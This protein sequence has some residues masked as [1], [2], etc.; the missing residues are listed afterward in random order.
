VRSPGLPRAAATIA[1]ATA[2]VAFAA[3]A[4]AACAGSGGLFAGGR[5]WPAFAADVYAMPADARETLQ[6]ATAVEHAADG[7]HDAA[8]RLAILTATPD[9]S[10]QDL[11]AALDLLDTAEADLGSRDGGNRDFIAFFRPL[12]L[13]L[14]SQRSAL[15]TESLTRQALEAQI[16]ELKALEESLNAGRTER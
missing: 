5:D 13:A 6:A 8:L 12:V 15:A 1:P 16:E 14:Q 2:T 3:A 9:A 7:G 4:L 11:G 10:A